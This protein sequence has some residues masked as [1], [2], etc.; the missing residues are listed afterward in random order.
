MQQLYHTK[1]HAWFYRAFFLPVSG[2]NTSSPISPMCY[3]PIVCRKSQ[4]RAL[5]ACELEDIS[6]VHGSASCH[7]VPSSLMVDGPT[8]CWREEP[9]SSKCFTVPKS[10]PSYQMHQAING[11]CEQIKCTSRQSSTALLW[12]CIMQWRLL[13]KLHALERIKLLRMHIVRGNVS[14]SAP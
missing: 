6:V 3:W 7:S 1:A 2:V 4:L 9:S 14:I 8:L 5:L 13:S 11:I 10:S 12:R